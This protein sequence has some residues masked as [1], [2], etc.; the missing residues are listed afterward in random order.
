MKDLKYFPII[1]AIQLLLLLLIPG[2]AGNVRDLTWLVSISLVFALIF[3][4]GTTR[5]I[6]A[7]NSSQ[8]Q[9][10]ARY[11]G[12]MGLRMLLGIILIVIY[13]KF[14][15]VINKAGTIFLICSYFVY[16]GFEI[17]IIL[18]KLRTNSEK[19]KNAD[20]PQK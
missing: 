4:F 15:P 13:L 16:M 6:A 19:P 3:M 1:F 9:F 12:T 2:L 7:F 10:N 5:I 11:F 18:S 17:K 14:S 8:S 20:N